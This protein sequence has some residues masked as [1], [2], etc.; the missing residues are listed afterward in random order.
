DVPERLVALRRRHQPTALTATP[1][2]DRWAREGGRQVSDRG[3]IPADIAK[4]FEEAHP[5]LAAVG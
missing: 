4:A 5:G 2:D 3:R 1:D